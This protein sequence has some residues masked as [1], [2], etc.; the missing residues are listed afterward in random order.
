MRIYF[1]I[2]NETQEKDY[3]SETQHQLMLMEKLK[4]KFVLV[5]NTN[6]SLSVVQNNLGWFNTKIASSM[7]QAGTHKLAWITSQSKH[8]E[9]LNNEFL[10]LESIPGPLQTKYF[11]DELDAFEWF[12]H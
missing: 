10:E 11:T 9:I 7:R 5:C 12:N 3:L 1:S 4:P 8:S 6:D 2:N